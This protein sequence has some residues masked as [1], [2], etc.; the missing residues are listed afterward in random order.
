LDDDVASL[1]NQKMRRSGA[2]FKATVNHFLRQGL[3]APEAHER[4]PFV[5][6]PRLLGLPPGLS[7]D[8]IE[9]LIEALEGPLHR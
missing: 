8:K 1:L 9:D 6:T 2:S 3:T 5:I 7:Y 4:K